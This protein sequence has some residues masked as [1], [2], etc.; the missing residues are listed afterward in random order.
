MTKPELILKA[1]MAPGEPVVAFVEN[2]IRLVPDHEIDTFRAVVEMKGY[3]KNDINLYVEVF[4]S[5]LQSIA[6]AAASV[7]AAS[8]GGLKST[9]P[10]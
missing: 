2:Y 9:S 8:N 6:A 4:K 3:K 1:I 10:S 5:K 7:P